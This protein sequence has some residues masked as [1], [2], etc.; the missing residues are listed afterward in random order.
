MGETFT[1]QRSVAGSV[2]ETGT[3]NPVVP[4]KYRERHALGGEAGCGC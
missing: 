2:D 4:S 3:D 1:L